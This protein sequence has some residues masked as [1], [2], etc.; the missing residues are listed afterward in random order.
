MGSG[1]SVS[2]GEGEAAPVALLPEEAVA[3][4]LLLLGERLVTPEALAG[5]SA[6][7]VGVPSALGKAPLE[8]QGF[9]GVGIAVPRG[10]VLR[11]RHMCVMVLLL[12]L[13]TQIR[14]QGS[15]FHPHPVCPARPAPLHGLCRKC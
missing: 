10:A 2:G 6:V 14:E 12:K 4:L 11:D 8:W 9:L 7:A 5:P 1:E 15:S 13:V 3:A